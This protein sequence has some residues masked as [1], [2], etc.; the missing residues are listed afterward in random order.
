MPDPKDY[1]DDSHQYVRGYVRRKNAEPTE[2]T[3][4]NW[5]WRIAWY[6]RLLVVIVVI[7]LFSVAL[8]RYPLVLLGLFVALGVWLWLSRPIKGGFNLS[9]KNRK[10]GKMRLL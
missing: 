9:K 4:R 1:M 8:M 6:W 5:F 10:S 7:V 2:P 3:K